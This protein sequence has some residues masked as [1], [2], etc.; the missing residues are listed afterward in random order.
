MTQ[1]KPWHGILTATA[2]PYRADLSVDLDKY[3]EHIAWLAANNTHGVVPNGS[4]GEYQV[5]TETERAAMVTTAVAAAP[6][7]FSVVPGAGA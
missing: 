3:A 6:A 7:G 1:S 2:T 4:L 5:L